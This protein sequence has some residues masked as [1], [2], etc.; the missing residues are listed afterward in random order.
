MD[1]TFKKKCDDCGSEISSSNWRRHVDE[2]HG[3]A[4][5]GFKLVQ[6]QTGYWKIGLLGLATC[7]LTA[8]TTLFGAGF[9]YVA[10]GPV[11]RLFRDNLKI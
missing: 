10:Y 1:K 11:T 3:G 5:V 8:M 4:E 9:F 7:L 6:K 2:V